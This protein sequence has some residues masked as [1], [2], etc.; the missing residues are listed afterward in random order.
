MSDDI[1][2]ITGALQEQM[3]AAQNSEVMEPPPRELRELFQ[4][5][6]LNSEPGRQVWAWMQHKFSGE[7]LILTEQQRHEHNVIQRIKHIIGYGQTF[8]GM[9]LHTDAAASVA[10]Q[11]GF[12]EYYNQEEIDE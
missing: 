11:Y 2:S 3:D 12:A 1:R 7:T 9:K 10:Q 5:V 8:E 6:F 4:Q